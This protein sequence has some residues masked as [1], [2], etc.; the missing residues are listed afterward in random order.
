MLKTC[1]E[2]EDS[3]QRLIVVPAC[4]SQNRQHAQKW[5]HHHGGSHCCCYASWREMKEKQYADI[6]PC[7]GTTKKGHRKPTNK[8]CTLTPTAAVFSTAF[9]GMYFLLPHVKQQQPKW[10][11]KACSTS[12]GLPRYTL[13]MQKCMRLLQRVMMLLFSFMP[14]NALS[15]RLAWQVI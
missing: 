3:T 11:L 2:H 9:T 10:A 12:N 8:L 13:D 4:R 1:T 6:K 5:S 15:K 7:Q 14:I